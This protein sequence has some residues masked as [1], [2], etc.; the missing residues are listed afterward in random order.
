MAAVMT[1]ESGDSEKIAAAIEE[2]KRLGIV[3]L[4][5]DVNKSGVGFSLEKLKDLTRGKQVTLEDIHKFINTLEVS[6]KIKKELSVK[7]SRTI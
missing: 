2:C 1:A 4:P 3:V 6:E 7:F 5:P